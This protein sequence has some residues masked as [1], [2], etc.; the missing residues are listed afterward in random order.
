MGLKEK[1]AAKEFQETHFESLKEQIVSNAK[2]DVELEVEWDT[3]AV[4]NFSH[5][6]VDAWTKIFFT[7]TI[8]AFK[9]MCEESFTQ[10]AVQEGVKKI[11]ICN[12]NDISNPGRWATL[13]DGVLTLDHAI[14]NLDDADRRK[15]GLIDS[16]E[17]AL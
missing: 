4:D 3:L 5:L 12:R 15:K 16:V 6:Y 9:E 8:E 11:I 14:C 10:E 13:E 7:P 1:R 17:N 2:Y